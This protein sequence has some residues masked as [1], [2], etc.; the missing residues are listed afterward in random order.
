MPP[1]RVKR[2]KAMPQG[3]F[4]YQILEVSKQRKA[5]AKKK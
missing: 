3:S 1:R 2:C 4:R 5:E